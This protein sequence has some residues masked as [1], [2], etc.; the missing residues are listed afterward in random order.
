MD[1]GYL[2]DKSAR[3][4]W[5]YKFLWLF[6][7]LA[8]CTGSFNVP[9]APYSG[10][11]GY[12]DPNNPEAIPPA[13]QQYLGW[14]ENTDPEQMTAIFFGL[15]CLGFILQFVFLFIRSAG[16]AGLIQGIYQAE[17]DVVTQSF[18]SVFQT[19]KGFTTR[20]AGLSLV[21]FLAACVVFFVGFCSFIAVVGSFGGA[22]AGS[23]MEPGLIMLVICLMCVIYLFAGLLTMILTQA[24]AAI[25]IENVGI[26]EGWR[27][28]SQVFKSNLG[29][30]LL[31]GFALVVA[32]LVITVVIGGIFVG[33]SMAA[34][35]SPSTPSINPFTI[36]QDETLY[37][38]L[39]YS[40]ILWPFILLFQ[41]IVMTYIRSLWTLAYIRNRP[42]D[43]EVIPEPGP[44]LLPESA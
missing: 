38:M 15:M 10:F 17:M 4:T 44:E 42:Q 16:H 35:G 3:I 8:S 22:K 30:Y 14:L 29:A 27:R 34:L 31:L 19:S 20:I 6:G 5:K 37:K 1:I 18:G 12:I 9:S 24:Q 11:E 36:W 33:I 7:I 41:G 40:L 23:G 43:G 28:G 2:I 26:S 21:V 32:G 39:G 25:V 13:L